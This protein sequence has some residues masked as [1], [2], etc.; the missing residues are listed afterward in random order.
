VG[1]SENILQA[2]QRFFEWHSRFK[3]GRVSDEDDEISGDQAPAR[4]QKMLT[5]F[6]YSFIKTIAEQSTS[7]QTLLGSITEFARRS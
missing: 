2:E 7:L 4:R 3:A 5:K 1:L 6:E